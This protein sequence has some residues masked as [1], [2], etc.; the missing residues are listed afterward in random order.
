MTEDLRHR[1]RYLRHLPVTCPFDVVEISIG[2]SLISPSTLNEFQVKLDARKRKRN[3]KA[4]E[5]RKI[6]RRVQAEENKMLGRT[7]RMKMSLQSS[8]HFPTFNNDLST[9]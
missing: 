1:L 6:E 8:R 7:P 4:K 9:R 3:K 2:N 5:E